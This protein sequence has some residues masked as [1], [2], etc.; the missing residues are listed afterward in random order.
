M[1]ENIVAEKGCEQDELISVIIPTYNRAGLLER[2]VQ[3]V[4]SQTYTN[5]ELLIIDDCSKDNTGEIVKSLSDKRIRYYRNDH[6]M[7]PA[8]SRNRGAL[9][10]KGSLIAYQDSDDE[11]LPDK[12]MRLMEVWKK[13]KNEETGMIYHEM[14]EQG[15]S[16][17]I[18]SRDIPLE[19]KSKEIFR[20]ML[21]YPMIGATASLIRK[22]CLEEL[23]RLQ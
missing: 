8:A 12:L 4:L 16:T 7:G 10:A 14:Q 22:S 18:P 2:S 20:H 17:F 19:W 15:V 9:L 21:L 13:E 6:N 23:G 3:S 5:L 1:S 11:W